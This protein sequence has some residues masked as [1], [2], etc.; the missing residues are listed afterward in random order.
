MEFWHSINFLSQQ[1][2]PMCK[3]HRYF[4]VKLISIEFSVKF[5]PLKITIW[6]FFVI[7]HK[8]DSCFIF[9]TE[10]LILKSEKT[11]K[12]DVFMSKTPLKSCFKITVKNCYLNA[13]EKA[14]S[15]VKD[16]DF[17]MKLTQIQSCPKIRVFSH[18]LCCIFKTIFMQ[19][20]LHATVENWG[21]FW[22][23]YLSIFIC[24][25]RLVKI[26][27]RRKYWTWRRML[28]NWVETDHISS[29]QL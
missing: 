9:T 13:W 26:G 6:T 15:H 11:L 2:L 14:V 24:R 20:N 16:F 21:E 29:E 27:G 25:D 8:G 12:N 10:W 1:I 28:F 23:N 22:A 4:F 18:K 17:L 3:R 7:F 5:K 19:R